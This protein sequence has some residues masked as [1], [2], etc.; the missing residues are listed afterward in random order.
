VR[1][2]LLGVALAGILGGAATA[3]AGTVIDFNLG[4]GSTTLATNQSA[5]D[6]NEAGSGVAIGQGPFGTPFVVGSSFTFLYQANMVNLTPGPNPAGLDTS[7]DG[8]WNPTT[9]G[10]NGPFEFTVVARL[11]ET[12]SSF[13]ATPNACGAGC[14][15]FNATFVRN[16]ALPSYV[17]IFYDSPT[18]TG[19]RGGGVPAN[20]TTG[21]GFDDGIEVM[22]MHI[23]DGEPG[24]ATFS[25]FSALVG[26]NGGGTG[27][28]SA[29]IHGSLSSFDDFVNPA[30]LQ[31]IQA[32]IMDF[33]YQADL[34]YPPGTSDTTSFHN[35]AEPDTLYPVHAVVGNDLVLKVDGANQFTTLPTQ[36]PEPASLL[37]LGIGLLG[38][39]FSVRGRK[40]A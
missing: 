2:T 6:W 29:K 13:T 12:V 23:D 22:R 40:A 5:V 31:G 30:Y 35:M 32:L 39:G 7:S 28:G 34:N 27:Q 17:S 19:S 1:K 37:L 25:T 11:Q 4:N 26:G 9:V 38:L 33:D 15:L 18:T 21:A 14:S 24:F 10:A 8:T 3:Q 16:P 36:L 20:T